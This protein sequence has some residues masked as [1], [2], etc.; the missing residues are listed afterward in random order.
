MQHL[1]LFLAFYRLLGDKKVSSQKKG[2]RPE[3]FLEN[4]VEPLNPSGRCAL[5][6]EILRRYI[7]NAVRV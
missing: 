7:K 5:V 3:G 4:L 6:P 1:P 2:E